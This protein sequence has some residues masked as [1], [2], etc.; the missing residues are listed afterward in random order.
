[1][2]GPMIAD[3]DVSRVQMASSRRIGSNVRIVARWCCITDTRYILKSVLEWDEQR[4][5]P[6]CEGCEAFLPILL[7]R[8]ID[9]CFWVALSMLIDSLGK[10]KNSPTRK[11]K[12]REGIIIFLLLSS[13]WPDEPTLAAPTKIKLKTKASRPSEISVQI[14]D[15]NTSYEG[16]P[17][18][19]KTNETSESYSPNLPTH[20]S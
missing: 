3:V 19:V 9:V 1:M 2:Y 11:K 12:K 7:K 10:R 16:S 5:V 4:V 14:L 20:E 6:L 15:D 17:S 13:Y 18:P 8:V